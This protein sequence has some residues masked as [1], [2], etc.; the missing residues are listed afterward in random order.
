VKA[1]GQRLGNGVCL[2][3]WVGG[4][5]VGSVLIHPALSVCACVSVYVDSINR[6]N[7]LIPNHNDSVYKTSL[8]RG[9]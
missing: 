1:E 4:E 3:G 7:L 8:K 5:L 2:W 6:T 9:K